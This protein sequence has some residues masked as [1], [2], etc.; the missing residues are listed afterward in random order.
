MLLNLVA[1]RRESRN[2]SLGFAFV[3]GCCFVCCS[4]CGPDFNPGPWRS[5]PPDP[6]WG[7]AA[8][9]RGL[10]GRTSSPSKSCLSCSC[11]DDRLR[12]SRQAAWRAD[13]ERAAYLVL[14]ACSSASG[15]G[16]ISRR[17]RCDPDEHRDHAST[18]NLA[19]VGVSRFLPRPAAGI[20]EAVLRSSVAARGR[21]EQP[22]GLA[23]VIALFRLKGS[24]TWTWRLLAGN[25]PGSCMNR[26]AATAHLPARRAFG[27]LGRSRCS[28]LHVLSGYVSRLP[29]TSARS[30][31]RFELASLLASQVACQRSSGAWPRSICT[32]R[33]RVHE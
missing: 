14:S 31:P 11:R 25:Q 18:G 24:P 4:P 1:R 22:Y 6:R 29:P 10:F 28:R 33:R 3:L 32:F 15:L 17:G 16:V 2:L 23:I 27:P 5:A 26:C 19:L 21:R 13:H 20:I 9:L 30:G 12:F 7:S 8:E